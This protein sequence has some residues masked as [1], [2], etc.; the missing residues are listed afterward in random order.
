MTDP[1]LDLGALQEVVGIRVETHSVVESTMNEAAEDSGPR[2]VLHLAERQRAGRG[3]RGRSWSSPPG[4]LYA[5]LVWPDEPGA[6]SPAVMGAVQIAWA[7]SVARAGGPRCRV[8]W[9]NDGILSGR[10]WAGLLAERGPGPE[11]I[12][13]RLGMGANLVVVPEIEDAGA[14]PATCL[15]DHWPGEPGLTE[16]A[17]ILLL[18]AVTVLREGP[19]GVRARLARWSRHDALDR[20]AWLLVRHGGGEWEGRY[21]GVDLDG[22]LRLDTPGSTMRL[23]AGEVV[24]LRPASGPPVPP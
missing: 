13:L 3:R 19:G 5:T 1:P 18:A 6:L 23:A 20:D 2:P 11:G 8:K 15:A 21:G 9:P 14:L 16:T 10:K 17:G 4:N 7:E 22:R 12:E 24:R